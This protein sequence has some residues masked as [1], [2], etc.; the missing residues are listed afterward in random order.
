M[1][2]VNKAH[3]PYGP[4]FHVYIY[5]YVNDWR[6]CAAPIESY[7]LFF[8]VGNGKYANWHDCEMWEKMYVSSVGLCNQSIFLL[9]HI[10]TARLFFLSLR[11]LKKKLAFEHTL[12][13]MAKSL[14]TNTIN[15]SNWVN[16]I[17]R[18][19][20][21]LWYCIPNA[22]RRKIIIGKKWWYLILRVK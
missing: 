5:I 12:F 15:I 21:T 6:I 14:D 22:S 16:V 20:A 18:I 10:P 1:G 7:I 17:L 19:Y 13:V 8:F 11:Y 2:Q 9:F 4:N 3:F